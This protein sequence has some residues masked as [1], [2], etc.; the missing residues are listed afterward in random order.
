MRTRIAVVTFVFLG[1]TWAGPASPAGGAWL[2][3]QPLAAWNK[4][5]GKIPR[6]PRF[7]PDPFLDKQ[8]AG[9]ARAAASAADQAVV[10]A[11]WKLIGSSQRFG[12]TEVVLGRSG[13]DGM[14]RPLGYQ[15]FVF[16][17]GKFA[18]TL[19]PRPM[20]S[21]TDGAAQAPELWSAGALS[22]TFSRYT[23]RD[24]LCCPSRISTVR[25]RI[26]SGNKGPVATA[27]DV[28]TA[29]T[30]A[31][32]PP[33]PVPAPAAAGTSGVAL[34]PWQLVKIQMID[35]AVLVPDDPARYTFELA[36]DG[37]AAVRADCNRGSGTYALDGPALSFGPLA[38]TRAMCPPGSISDRY[39]AE[40]GLVATW[41]ERDGTLVLATRA[42]GATLEFRPAP[43][44]AGPPPGQLR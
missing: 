5:G 36:G 14:C 38:T 29:S 1:V 15:G 6:A 28:S 32:P 21:R 2:D 12:D 18:G 33:P 24:P 9:Q 10:K 35:G 23:G 11:G 34:R 17:G 30:S 43:A 20:D 26:E 41:T 3:A 25:Y 40:L 7:D 27:T 16:S 22:V 42:G 44:A 8:C 37:R 4:A 19:A 13:V 31:V 39:L